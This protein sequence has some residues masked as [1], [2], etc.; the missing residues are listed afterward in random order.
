MVDT[1]ERERLDGPSPNQGAVYLDDFLSVKEAEL[2]LKGRPPANKGFYSEPSL[3]MRAYRFFEALKASSAAKGVPLV[4]KCHWPRNAP[5]CLVLTHDIDWMTYTP[6]HRAVMAGNSPGRFLGL[7][8]RYLLDG[9]RTYSISS[10]LKLEREYGVRSTFLFRTKYA[11]DSRLVAGAMSECREAGSELALHAA[12]RSHR[13]PQEMAQEKTA[14]E[15]LAGAK[16]AGTRQHRL[17]F[18]PDTTWSC[19]ESAGLAYDLTFGENE[20]TGFIAGLCHPYHPLNPSGEPYALLAI[21]TSFMD[22][23]ALHARLDY[24]EIVT[25]LNRLIESVT[26]LNGCLCVNFHNTYVDASFFP[27][28]E[29]A[30]RVLLDQCLRAGYWSAT[31]EECSSWWNRRE[32]AVLSASWSSGALKAETSDPMVGVKI[33]W[34]DG[35]TEILDGDENPGPR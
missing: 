17:K 10:L 28:V 14:L 34:P 16:V 5:G 30:Y 2:A 4:T 33:H 20:R 13:D 3:S 9:K 6:L 18:V 11:S 24:Q 25:I 1:R 8:S 27:A 12:G 15:R 31:A 23:T 29:R 22:W 19:A 35:R 32:R 7:A 26:A 21:P